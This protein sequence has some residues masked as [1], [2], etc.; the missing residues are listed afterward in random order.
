MLPEDERD[1]LHIRLGKNKRDRDLA[2]FIAEDIAQ[3]VNVS[4]LVKELLHKYYTGAP[5]PAHMR[6]STPEPTDDDKQK[7]LS[8]KLKKISFGN[9]AKQ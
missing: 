9:L 2:S 7:A 1:R 6:T 3:G 8:A 4:N 5:M